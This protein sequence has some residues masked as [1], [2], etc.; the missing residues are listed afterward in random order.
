MA[1][2]LVIS[3]LAASTDGDAIKKQIDQWSDQ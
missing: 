3:A 1:Q 2:L